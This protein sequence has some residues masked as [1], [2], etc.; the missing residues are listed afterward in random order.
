[1]ICRARCTSCGNQ[2]EIKGAFSLGKC[3]KCGSMNWDAEI[4]SADRYPPG[5]VHEAPVKEE[6]GYWAKMQFGWTYLKKK[7]NPEE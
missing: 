6:E 4:G 5:W 2:K 1:M 7:I 3:E